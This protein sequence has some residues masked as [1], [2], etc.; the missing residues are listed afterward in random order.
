MSKLALKIVEA[1][2]HSLLGSLLVALIWPPM[3]FF[4]QA[5]SIGADASYSSLFAASVLVLVPVS[6]FAWL[7]GAVARGARKP[8]NGMD[9]LHKEAAN[10]FDVWSCPP[11]GGLRPPTFMRR[12]VTFFGRP[13]TSN[14][15]SLL[16]LVV[17]LSLLG[18]LASLAWADGRIWVDRIPWLALDDNRRMAAYLIA[19]VLTLISLTHWA[20]RQRSLLAPLP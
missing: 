11:E 15:A 1:I 5:A 2:Q 6:F 7:L 19:G 17:A 9:R 8:V 4:S 14:L 16:E 18:F 10:G 3:F 13:P 12:L 20:T